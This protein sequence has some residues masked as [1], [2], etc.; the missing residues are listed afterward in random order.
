MTSLVGT[1]RLVSFVG[2]GA[3][4]SETANFGPTPRGCLIYDAGGRMSVHIARSEP[5]PSASGDS[6]GDAYF[7][8]FG[9]YSVAEDGGTVTH[10]IEGASHPDY[11]GT[12]QRRLIRWQGDRLMLS[13]TPGGTGAA[14]VTYVAIWERE[15]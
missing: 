10:H 2:H 12:D 9:T 11:A 3:D 15:H 7:G 8:Y 1:W 4:G 13:T 14:G 5:R 6:S